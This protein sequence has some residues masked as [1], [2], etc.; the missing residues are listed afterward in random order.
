MN[1]S[2]KKDINASKEDF[3]NYLDA[4]FDMIRLNMAEN[5]SKLIAGFTIKL[6]ILFAFSFVMLF[7]SL[8]FAAWINNVMDI[9]GIGYIILAG[10]YVFFIFIFWLLRHRI[11]E[12]PIIQS[13]IEM[14]F[15]P[16]HNFES[17]EK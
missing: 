7:L 2:L 12:R 4:R 8:A 10:I 16:D 11:V 17:N 14:F 13:M 6:T 5:F 1:D 3:Q 9:P 15:P